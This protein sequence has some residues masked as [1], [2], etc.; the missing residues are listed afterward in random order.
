MLSSH[1][2]AASFIWSDVFRLRWINNKGALAT[3]EW[4]TLK[5]ITF[6]SF[7]QA[8]I[9][10]VH[11]ASRTPPYKCIIGQPSYGPTAVSIPSRADGTHSFHCYSMLF[12]DHDAIILPQQLLV[13]ALWCQLEC[14][15]CPRK[16]NLSLFYTY[17]IV[18][19]SGCL[20]SGLWAAAV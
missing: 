12:L 14:N 7:H 1:P 10:F 5:P 18:F 16:S 19:F 6:P 2:R 3:K 4:K 15:Y 13:Q 11:S 20:R 8:L 17:F 9:Y